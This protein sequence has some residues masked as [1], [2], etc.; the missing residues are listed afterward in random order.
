MTE[1]GMCRATRDTA[2]SIAD[3]GRLAGKNAVVIGGAGRIGQAIGREFARAGANVALVDRRADEVRAAAESCAQGGP[4][5]CTAVAAYLKTLEDCEALAQE[6]QKALGSV[7]ILVNCPGGIYRA[8]FLDHSVDALGELWDINVRLPFM[9]CRV[10]GRIMKERGSGKIINFASVGGVRPEATHAGYCAA[11]AGLIAFSRVAAMELAP[12]N[13][14]VNVVAPGPTETVPFTS[15][16]YLE[17][18]EV[19]RSIEERTPAGRIGHP[20]DHAGLVVFLASSES[21]WVSGQVIMSD[22]GIGLV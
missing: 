7:D 4:G 12:Y 14:Q 21:N 8:A 5:K 9:A 1:D 10:F 3:S 19:L 20:E 17:H 16:F 13:I 11:K 2:G 15:S 22:G 6:C 18:P